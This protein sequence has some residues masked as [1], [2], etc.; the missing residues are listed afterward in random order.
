MAPTKV[1]G[2]YE[3]WSH[4]LGGILDVAGVPGFLANRTAIQERAGGVEDEWVQFFR[5]WYHEF[6]CSSVLAKELVPGVLAS[7]LLT[8]LIKTSDDRAMG[9]ALGNALRSRIGRIS[10]GLRL[11]QAGKHRSGVTQYKLVIV[12]AAEVDPDGPPVNV[13]ESKEPAGLF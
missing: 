12:N 6:G 3:S 1:L 7:Q 8:G 11:D 5:H 4:V 10:S 13:P 9:Q 2:S